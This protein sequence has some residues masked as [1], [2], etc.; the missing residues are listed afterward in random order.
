[1]ISTQP[2]R[3]YLDAWLR[4]TRKQ[5][6]ASGRLTQT[7]LALSLSEG[8]SVADWRVRLRQ[9]LENSEVPTL[10]LL[11]KIDLLLSTPSKLKSSFSRQEE[12]F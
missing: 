9:F 6:A 4:R 5:F 2:E 10:D 12:F 8:G 11:T 3:P 7:A 1:M